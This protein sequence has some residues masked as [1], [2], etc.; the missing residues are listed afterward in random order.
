MGGAVQLTT[1]WTALAGDTSAFAIEISL[2]TDP[3]SHHYD[4]AERESWGA[5]TLWVN[6]VNVTEH[7]EQ[8][9]VLRSAHWYLLPTIEWF[10]RNWDALFH[11][12]RLPL[13]NSGNDAAAAMTRLLIQPLRSVRADLDEFER[14]ET[15]QAWWARHNLVDSVAGGIF[16]DVYMRRWGDLVE[17]SVGAAVAAGAPSHFRHENVDVVGRVP[18]SLVASAVS[19]VLERAV[20]ELRRRR[21]E[22]SRLAALARAVGEVADVFPGR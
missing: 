7:I 3:D 22:S 19:D 11:E 8:G 10:V 9:E 20:A 12:E 14:L 4:P 17:I 13:S 5:L 1:T 6:G 16:P 21:P 15:W 18:V 2:L